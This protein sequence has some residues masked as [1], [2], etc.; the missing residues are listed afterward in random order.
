MF[1]YMHAY[2]CLCGCHID[3]MHE[4][5]SM[6]NMYVT[7]ACIDIKPD[8]IRLNVCMYVS[9]AHVCLYTRRLDIRMHVCVCTSTGEFVRERLSI[10]LFMKT[11]FRQKHACLNIHVRAHTSAHT[12]EMFALSVFF[13][14]VYVARTCTYLVSVGGVYMH[15]SCK[16]MSHV[17][18]H[19]LHTG[20]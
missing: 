14:E 18:A 8:H 15:M 20:A 7:R 3:N 2:V 10:F 9:G 1:V 4:C 6:S 5:V 19:I 17:Y 11:I 12:N 13:Q 16:C